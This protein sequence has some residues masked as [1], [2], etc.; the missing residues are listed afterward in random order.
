[1]H[2]K[3]VVAT[4]VGGSFT[5]PFHRSIVGLLKY[6]LAKPDESRLLF[7]VFD[8][9]GL[10]VQLNREAIVRRFLALPWPEWLLMIDSD[11]EFHPVLLEEILARAGT[12]TIV[13]A[14][15][16][17]GAGGSV[18]YE[19]VAPGLWRGL[20]LD[21]L[22]NEPLFR[23]GHVASAVLLIHRTAL[24]DIEDEFG[25]GMSFA[26]DRVWTEKGFKHVPE[27]LAFCGRA[28]NAGHHPHVARG[29]SLL[30]HFKTVPLQDAWRMSR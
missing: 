17:L 22:P 20:T 16:P 28:M 14:S 15:V 5:V 29:F 8:S 24:V 1:M 12:A 26:F 21:E 6:E 3:V 23:W 11:I 7:D 4:P 27:D 9:S 18:C 2:G 30:R 10:Y 25:V 13:A 19:G